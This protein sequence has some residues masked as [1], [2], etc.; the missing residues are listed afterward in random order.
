[1]LPPR[2][3]PAGRRRRA[4]RLARL[5]RRA[6]GRPEL[7]QGRHVRPDG[8]A[9]QR[10]ASGVKMAHP[11]RTVVVGCGDGCYSLAGFELM[12]AVAVRHPRHLG[13]LQRRRVQ[14]DQAL[15]AATYIES[16]LVEFQNPDFAAYARA[17]GADGYAVDTHRGVRGRLRRRARAPAVRRVIDATHHPLGPAALQPVAGGRRRR[18]RRALVASA[19]AANEPAAGRTRSTSRTAAR[20]GLALA[21]TWQETPVGGSAEAERVEFERW[22]AR[23][24]AC[25]SPTRRRPARS[26]VPHGVDRAFHA[27]VDARR[28]RRRAALPRRC[29]PSCEV[30]FAQ[31]G[32]GLP[33]LVRV[34]QRRPAPASP[35]PSPTCAASRCASTSPTRSARPADDELPGLARP[36]RPAVRRVRRRPPP[37]ARSPQVAR[38]RAA[39]ACCSARARRCGCSRNVLRR[40]RPHGRAASRPRPTGAAARCAGAGRSPSATCCARRPARRR[41]RAPPPDDPDY[42][43]T[44]GRR[45][46]SRSGDVALRAV[47]P[48]LRRRE[49]HADRGHR[50]RV[51]RAR[52]RRRVP[53]AVL[54][55]LPP[56]D[57]D[58]PSTRSRRRRVVDALAFNPWNTTD[59]FRPLGNLNRARKAAYDAELRAPAGPTAGETDA[60]AAQRGR[61]APRA[62]GLPAAQPLRRLAPAA[63]AARACSTSTSSAHVL[64]RDNLHRHRDAGGAA[65]GAAGA[66]GAARRGGAGRAQRR[67]HAATTCR[68]RAMGAVGADVRPQPAAR[69]TGPTCSTSRTRSRSA[70]SCSTAST[71][72]RRGRSTSSPPPGSSS[73][74]TTGSTTPAHPL[75]EDDVDRAAAARHDVDEHAR[76]ASRSARC[77]S[78]ATSRYAGG[79]PGDWP[80]LRQHDLALVGRLG[81]LRRRRRARPAMLRDGAK[82]RLDRTATCPT[83]AQRLRA[84]RLQRELVAG[85]QRPA[86]AVRPRAQPA[87]RRAARALP[88]L[89]RR[90]RLPDRAADRRRR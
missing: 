20:H 8:R 45:A 13:H 53:V 64:R 28:R 73:R 85:A 39:G 7:P 38:P 86:H 3:D 61:R 78:P 4:P 75:G 46:G 43:S 32:R 77:G 40:P 87:L 52:P 89:E 19:S 57:L 22:R 67:R 84:H 81:G 2:G 71:S 27:K 65:D 51:D 23:S 14:A 88:G 62:R 70:G 74:C 16:G 63:A 79:R 42:L 9:R 35:T 72:S 58:R 60:A 83:D 47:R 25:S 6:R 17:C 31:P 44:R 66:A 50:R 1:M 10:R 34:L 5:L 21:A 18:A 49:A 12:T 36:R 33:D 76:R 55:I 90:A 59:E 69:S 56:R 80:G 29:P 30:G 48:A 82:L 54:T 41:R 37:A 68:R 26:G 24:C 15:P 11:D